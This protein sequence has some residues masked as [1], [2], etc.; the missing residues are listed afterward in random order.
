MSFNPLRKPIGL[1][2]RA[3]ILLAAGLVLGAA[4]TALFSLSL[5]EVSHSYLRAD[6]ARQQIGN[7]RLLL[8]AM[9]KQEVALDAYVSTSDPSYLDTYRTAGDEADTAFASLSGELASPS[10][11]SLLRRLDADRT[12][13]LGLST[14]RQAEPGD[15]TL[16]A[17]AETRFD[18]LQ[19]DASLLQDRLAADYQAAIDDSQ[20]S[21]VT[22][23][24][25][26][27]LGAGTGALALLLLG[28]LF[29][30]STLSPLLRLLATAES[31]AAGK[32]VQVPATE[33]SDEVGALARALVAWDRTA[34]RQG[35]IQ[36]R[37][38]ESENRYRHLF[39]HAPVGIART[40]L[41]GRIA[42]ANPALEDM[43]GSS[44]SRLRGAALAG[45]LETEAPEAIPDAID[46]ARAGQPGQ[47]VSGRH[48]RPD[49]SLRRL[50]LALSCLPGP[51]GRQ[52]S[53]LVAM[54]EDVSDVHRHLERLRA[55]NRIGQAIV[56]GVPI[57]EVGPLIAAS[58]AELLAGDL[59]AVL[60]TAGD[61][62]VVEAAV[63]HGADAYRGMRMPIQGSLA[64][65]ALQEGGS[66]VSADL[67]EDPSAYGNVGIRLGTGPFVAAPIAAEGVIVVMNRRGGRGFEPADVELLGA[68]ARQAAFAY[69]Y[70]RSQE[71]VRQLRLVE[72]RERI[73]KNLQDSVIQSL[74][75]VSLTL[76]ALS[77]RAGAGDISERIDAA[78]AELDRTIRRMRN[79]VFGLSP[80]L[81]ADRHLDIALGILADDFALSSG[82]QVGVEVD[83]RL[84]AELSAAA[85]PLLEVARRALSAAGPSAGA[86]G[87][88][89]RLRRVE[90][91]GVLEIASAGPALDLS[92]LDLGA[93]DEQLEQV[94]GRVELRPG[95]GHGGAALAVTV[96]V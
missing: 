70:Q 78:E 41:E 12:A 95:N 13:W 49:G 17:P 87:L 40:D 46:R 5:A 85:G 43:I 53:G 54:F 39:A 56:E 82:I 2:A 47:V 10:E 83:R 64:G 44:R 48:L 25:T 4:L 74:F 30:R 50:E 59:A 29:F 26:A 22:A 76:Q 35:A 32:I 75:G 84:A 16:V 27:V 38:E 93:F 8:I 34:R 18:Q 33:R 71:R 68:F 14:R 72:E 73:A 61:E 3:G 69:E 9:I 67:Q 80:E 94:H 20:R 23:Q 28:R 36:R 92:A 66:A 52:P 45:L 91:A 79:L 7:E 60:R 62:L 42:E 96:P 86:G 51:S 77:L 89:L 88:T 6:R 31:M 21:T 24:L 81:E 1:K 55:I 11:R 19:A 65:R 63:G 58:A 37:A 15:P 90:G 57:R